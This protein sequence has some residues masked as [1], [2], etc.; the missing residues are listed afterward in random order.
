MDFDGAISCQNSNVITVEYSNNDAIELSQNNPNPFSG[1]T[2]ID[3]TI[4]EA[5]NITLEIL[6]IFGRVVKTLANN[7]TMKGTRKYS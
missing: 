2:H 6:D 5:Q 1:E 4:P 7:E 3:V